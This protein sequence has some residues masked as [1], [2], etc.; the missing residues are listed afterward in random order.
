MKR[1]VFHPLTVVILSVLFVGLEDAAAQATPTLPNVLGT[2][3]AATLS[4]HDAT[5]QA[6]AFDACLAQHGFVG[7]WDDH[8]DLVGNDPGNHACGVIGSEPTDQWLTGSTRSGRVVGADPTDQWLT[9]GTRSGGVMGSEPTDTWLVGGE[10]TDSW[11]TDSSCSVM[12]G[13][14]Q[15]DA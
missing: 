5:A 10:P 1:I 3:A 11:L 14:G 9:G 4:I 8:D 2:C 6:Q 13:M 7:D 12:I 15:K